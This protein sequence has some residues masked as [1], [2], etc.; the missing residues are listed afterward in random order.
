MA[1]VRIT[2]Y[3]QFNRFITDTVTDGEGHYHFESIHPG[4]Y[5]L[6]FEHE[7]GF[8]F[9]D[10][11]RGD[12]P[13]HD[14]DVD[15][16]TGRTVLFQLNAG[17]VSRR[18]GAGLIIPRNEIE[19]FV[20]DAQADSATVSLRWHTSHAVAQTGFR[21]Y[22]NNE[23]ERQGAERVRGSIEISE[24]YQQATPTYHYL[25]TETVEEIFSTEAYYWL[26]DVE[27]GVEI[28]EHGPI[29]AAGLSD[30]GGQNQVLVF[31]PFVN[32]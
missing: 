21:I 6:E 13:E 12:S 14:S 15:P 11:V 20:F 1:D 2:L 10:L 22:R 16:Y 24:Q 9:A 4:L 18:W 8:D 23:P 31:L 27:N 29:Q 3:D 7:T 28:A 19:L 25:M 26:I 17:E 30:A 5:T 32:R